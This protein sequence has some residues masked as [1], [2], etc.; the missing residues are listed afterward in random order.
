[1]SSYD[2][3]FSIDDLF[4]LFEEDS[5]GMKFTD[6]QIREMEAKFDAIYKQAAK[7]VNEKVTDFTNKFKVKAD[8][9][10][11]DLK[12]GKITQA[13]YNNW[14]RGQL[15]Q[16]KQWLALQEHITDV[17]V[18][19]NRAALDVLNKGMFNTLIA[20]ANWEAYELEHGVGI[21]LGFGL[22]DSRTV[23]N[24]IA[25]DP[26]VLP[27]KKLDP[28]KDKPWNMKTIRAEITQSIIQGES[29]DKLGKRLAKATGSKNMNAMMVHAR[30]AM[31]GAQNAG[32]QLR[33]DDAVNNMGIKVHKE[34]MSTLDTRTRDSHRD[35]DGEKRQTNEK[36][37]NGLRYPGDPEG[38]PRE[39]YNCRCTLV[40]DLDDY[41]SRYQRYDNIDG[42][43]IDNMTYREWYNAKFGITSIGEF[44]SQLGVAK[45]VQ[46]VNDLMN[47]QGW[48]RTNP[49]GIT[50]KADLTGCDLDSAKSIAA[51]Y[52]QIFEKFPQLKGRLDA[53]DAHPRG[54]GDNTYAWCYI[55]NGGKVQVN[56]NRYNNWAKISKSYES[57]VVSGWHPF[58]TT[59]ESI[60]THELGHAI[61]GLLAREG[62]KGGI[63]A[64]GEYRYASSSMRSTI[65]KRAAKID[66]DIA[67]HYDVFGS[68]R[69]MEKSV[70]LFVSDY[71]TKNPQEWF[72]ECFAEYITS[73]NPRTV[74]RLFGEEL[75]KLLEGLK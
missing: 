34:W 54:M 29:L 60:V 50:S 73:A 27:Y 43:P 9:K 4:K 26:K 75:E 41:P 52:D 57:D 35:M 33:L 19:S 42:V 74:A 44:Q 22:Y 71:A 56:P 14:M 18:N 5:S 36:F 7:E 2:F 48:F 1:M 38:H 6:A 51:S 59:A 65:M 24:L 32:R 21:N 15:F 11:N 69:G 66:E 37:S 49:A 8:K 16:K 61:D 31:T 20:N 10:L 63:T 23:T 58:G 39:V 47:N 46:E 68:K 70:G 67:F 62:I 17:Y 30:T 72:A 12:A 28:K 13:E 64:S 25:N 53:P 40:G 45:T 55:R 3:D